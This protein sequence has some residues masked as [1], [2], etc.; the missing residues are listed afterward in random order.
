MT[1][2]CRQRMFLPSRFGMGIAG[3]STE[4]RGCKEE[5]GTERNAKEEKRTMD[6][7]EKQ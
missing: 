3:I 4:V 1:G 6:G 2:L 7:K 5:G